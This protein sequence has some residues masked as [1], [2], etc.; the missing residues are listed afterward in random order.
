MTDQ[1]RTLPEDQIEDLPSP[2]A[3]N[4]QVA[5]GIIA[6][7]SGRSAPAAS[8]GFAGITDGTRFAVTGDGSV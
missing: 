8:N 6:V 1:S 3:D 7:L 4:D 5:G 2:Q